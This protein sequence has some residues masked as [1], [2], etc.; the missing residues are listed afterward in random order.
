MSL[1]VLL[2]TYA[3]AGGAGLQMLTFTDG[4]WTAGDTFPDVRNASFGTRSQRHDL[5]Y[6]V[7]EQAE[8]AVGVYR[9]SD[10][11]WQTVASV[12]TWGAEP[13]YVALDPNEEL[14][15][16][17]NYGSGSAAVFRIDP[18]SGVPLDPPIVLA[19]SGHGRNGDR[20]EGPHV[21][22][23]CFSP[24]GRWL[25]V[26][27][28]GTDKITSYEVGPDGAL[29]ARDV[30]YRA[31]D[32]SGPRHLVFHPTRPLALLLSELASTLTILRVEGGML[33]PV[34]TVSTLPPDFHG[35]SLGGHLS[36]NV[37]GDRVY[38]TNRGHDSIAIFRWEGGEALDLLQH[39]PS[40]GASPRSFVL[41]EAEHQMLVA[42][43]QSGDVTA[44]DI[45]PDGML[46]GRG[47]G[48]KIQGAVFLL[49][50]ET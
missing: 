39:V 12:P 25:Y 42:H 11:G 21:H 38:V 40:G 32:G 48:L 44:F 13:C 46:A 41:L 23:T 8:G 3:N 20:Q 45:L 19:D 34:G 49:V 4:A 5:Y 24:D 37:A 29:G 6:F 16:V 36:L 27:D 30:A 43:E 10:D 14:L 28:L 2:G 26:V 50:A 35:G 17:A 33:R 9:A 47:G 31:P 15:A 1:R 18:Q 22:C 7:D